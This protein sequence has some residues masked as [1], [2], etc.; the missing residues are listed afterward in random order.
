MLLF[1]FRIVSDIIIH[2]KA[3]ITQNDRRARVRDPTESQRSQYYKRLLTTL[4]CRI[5]RMLGTPICSLLPNGAQ[6]AVKCRRFMI[7]QQIDKLSYWSRDDWRRVEGE[8]WLCHDQKWDEAV[9]GYF[10][11]P[12]HARTRCRATNQR[13]TRSVTL[14]SWYC[15]QH[16]Q[17]RSSFLRSC[18]CSVSRLLRIR[19]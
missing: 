3:A 19:G 12:T 8:E 13:H 15:R 4:C 6:V 11:Y 1:D 18:Q 2:G 7:F 17:R 9:A 14:H 5:S 16:V 10:P